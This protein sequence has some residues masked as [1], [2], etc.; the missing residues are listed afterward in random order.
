LAIPGSKASFGVIEAAQARGEFDVLTEHGR[1]ALRV[2]SGG[3]LEKGLSE[4]N[5]M[6][7]D[8]VK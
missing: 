5:A 6:L 7:R 8:A 2:H 3:G 4:L 1:R